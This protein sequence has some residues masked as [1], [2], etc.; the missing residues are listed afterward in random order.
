MGNTS[1]NNEPDWMNYSPQD[2]VKKSETFG[3][4]KVKLN[5]D[6]SYDDDRYPIYSNQLQND[7]WIAHMFEKGWIDWNDFIPA[8][9][10]ALKNIGV[11]E[12]KMLIYY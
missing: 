12:I 9:F 3:K 6:M 1:L 7:D 11:K 8:Y 5:G 10:Q 4:W 2:R